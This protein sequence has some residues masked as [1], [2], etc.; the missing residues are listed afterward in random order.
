MF[1]SYTTARTS[2]V[3]LG[4][5]NSV[6]VPGIRTV[7]IPISVP[8]KW[9]KCILK[10]V[11]HVPGLEYQLLLVPSFEKEGFTISI[12][13]KC[14]WISYRPKLLATATIMG[15]LYK[16][17]IR[18]A[19]ETTLL[20][21]SAYFWYLRLAHIQL[22]TIR[23][24]AKSK[25]IQGLEISNSSKSDKSSPAS[26]PGKTHRGPIPKHWSFVNATSP[27]GRL[28]RKWSNRSSVLR[29]SRYFVTFIDFSRC[30]SIIM[31]EMDQIH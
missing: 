19:L 18:S 1:S 30:I 5:S 28:W 3:E 15:N 29:R 20:A 7:E 22:S 6:R 24:M 12:H 8:G 9:V 23:E 2:S 4:Y 11:L 10:A 14:C 31:W 17:D 27:V 25:S 16:M 21:N 13:S 26:V